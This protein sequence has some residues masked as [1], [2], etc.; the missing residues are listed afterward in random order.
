MATAYFTFF[1]LAYFASA[2]M[3][4]F[5]S[6]NRSTPLRICMIVQQAAFIGWMAY[7]WISDSYAEGAV[8]ATMSSPASTGS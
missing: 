2:G 6:E 1:A 3:I 8:A 5:T 4:T 7:A